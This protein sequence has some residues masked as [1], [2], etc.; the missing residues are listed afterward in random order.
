MT[1][2][3]ALAAG[4]ILAVLAFLLIPD[5]IADNA[6]GRLHL[7]LPG[8]LTGA[9]VAWMAVWWMTEAIP[10]YATALLPIVVLPMSGVQDFYDTTRPYAHPLIFLAMGGFIL[11]LALER[12]E[13][14]TRFARFVLGIVGS[15]P[16]RL[17]GGFM[18]V[19][20]ALSMWISNTAATVIM[21]PVALSVIAVNDASTS[22]HRRFTLCLLLGIAYACSIGGVGTL[23]GTGPNMFLAT[24]AAGELQRDLSFAAWMS[25]GVPLVLIFL[26]LAWLLLTRV[27][28]RLP[29]TAEHGPA[30]LLPERTPWSTGAKR[31]FAVFCLAV[32]GWVA[33]PIMEDLPYLSA[34]TDPGVAML[35]VL[36][37]FVIPSNFR[38][39]HFLMNWETAVKLPWGVLLLIGGGLALAAAISDNGIGKA[40]ALQ[41][42][43][44]QGV[45]PFVIVLFAVAL[46]SL[47][48]ELTSNLASTATLLPVLAA[49]ADGI[50]IDPLQI[51]VPTTLAASCAF[52]LPVATPPNSIVFGSGMLRVPD[53]VR[54]GFWL[55]TLGVLLI[56]LLVYP[57]VGLLLN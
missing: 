31:T 51:I 18:I 49:V 41:S 22:Y 28:F 27:I 40:L 24:F 39:G 25:L 9:L 10:I 3:Y 17:V 23:I 11:A 21:L 43:E 1:A 7:G 12:W 5:T 56:S 32:C 52:M 6:G 13:L 45:P 15:G 16:R 50:G 35:C 42:A 37:L 20:A 8:R 57:F 48:T 34:I 14:H 44:L 54:T 2:R 55:N 26:P 38:E 19:G 36:L 33:S 47:M 53:M 30:D 46:M 29:A 4:P